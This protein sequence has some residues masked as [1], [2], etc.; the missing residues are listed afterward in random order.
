MATH[1]V[2]DVCCSLVILIPAGV[3]MS[4]DCIIFTSRHLIEPL[5]PVGVVGLQF[6]SVILNFP[7]CYLRVCCMLVGALLVSFIPG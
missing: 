1:L 7:S 3:A 6:E 2:V 5:L 4:P